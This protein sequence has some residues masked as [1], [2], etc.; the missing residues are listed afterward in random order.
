MAALLVLAKNVS[1]LGWVG[2]DE[3]VE[4]DGLVIGGWV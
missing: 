3:A 2:E 4:G 1:A